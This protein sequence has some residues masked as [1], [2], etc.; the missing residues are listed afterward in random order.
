MVQHN[1]QQNGLQTQL[2]KKIKFNNFQEEATLSLYQ[3]LYEDSSFI[4][5]IQTLD[6][7][8]LEQQDGRPW[9]NSDVR[10]DNRTS[11]Q[12]LLFSIFQYLF[13]F[14][15]NTHN[16]NIQENY[17]LYIFISKKILFNQKKGKPQSNNNLYCYIYILYQLFLSAHSNNN[18]EEQFQQKQNDAIFSLNNNHNIQLCIL[19]YH[20]SKQKNFE[21]YQNTSYYSQFVHTSTQSQNFKKR[22]INA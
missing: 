5:G 8:M 15:Q 14:I 11:D 10:L 12:Q 18:D 6:H 17:Y 1:I 2:I 3:Y 4:Q 7:L 9:Q 16:F 19:F 13:I 21:T 20:S 22:S